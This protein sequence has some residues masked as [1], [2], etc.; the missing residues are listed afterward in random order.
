DIDSKD[1]H[2]DEIHKKNEHVTRYSS[3]ESD[4]FNNSRGNIQQ[5]QDFHGNQTG[6]KFGNFYDYKVEHP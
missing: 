2:P 5:K 6:Y 4:E 3:Q 1:V